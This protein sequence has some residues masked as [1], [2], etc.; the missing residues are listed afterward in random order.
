MMPEITGCS[1]SEKTSSLFGEGNKSFN[2]PKVFSVS[3]AGRTFLID[4]KFLRTIS[5]MYED[6]YVNTLVTV[7]E[8]VQA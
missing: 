1:I 5:E 7:P 8:I 6:Q 4:L 3:T 2:I